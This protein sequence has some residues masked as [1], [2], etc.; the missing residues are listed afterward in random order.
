MHVSR[1]LDTPARRALALTAAGLTLLCVNPEPTQGP[2]HVNLLLSAAMCLSPLVLLMRG[3]RVLIPRVDIPLGLVCLLVTAGPLLFHPETVRWRTMLFTCAYCVFFMALARTLRVSRLTPEF[4]CRLTR[5]IV[6]AFAILP[7]VQPLRLVT[8]LPV[9]MGT[10]DYDG[11]A[12]WKLNTLMTEPSHT[13]VALSTIMFFYTRT[14]RIEA[15]DETLWLCVCRRPWLW[16]AYVW[17]IFSTVNASSFVIGPLC[18][19]PYV[20]RRNALPVAGA[21]AAALALLYLTPAG[22]LPQ[23]SRVRDFSLAFLSGNPERMWEA[24]PSAATRVVPTL[25]G[26][27]LVDPADPAMYVGHG[28]DADIRDTPPRMPWKND[29]GSAG[30]LG[31]WHNYGALC[32]LAFWAAIA[33]VT[34]TPRDWLS[35]VAFLYAIQMSADYNMQLVWIIMAWSMAFKY[36]VAGRHRMLAAFPTAKT[37]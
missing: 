37:S 4:L 11:I 30:V 1:G 34:V 22:G 5:V 18:L 9:P 27:R 31:M 17:T 26:A 33:V 21:V 32:A 13:V 10:H 2:N 7:T 15:P 36:S 14:R 19:L 28:V 20:T 6:Y 24:D 12:P 16:A 23:V 25:E 8:G 29:N 35:W 3:A